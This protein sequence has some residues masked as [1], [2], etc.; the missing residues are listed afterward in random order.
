MKSALRFTMPYAIGCDIGVTNVKAVC[1][2]LG[3]GVLART[4]TTR[5]PK[6]PD[7]PAR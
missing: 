1:A 2:T 6:S 7:W 5:T 4:T 3:G